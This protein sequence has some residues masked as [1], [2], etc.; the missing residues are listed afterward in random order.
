ANNTAELRLQFTQPLI[1]RQVLGFRLTRNH[2]APPAAWP[3][4]AVRPLQV[5]SVR[6]FIGVSADAGLRLSESQVSGLT[7]IATA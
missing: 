1:G 3:L 4:P 6:G 2:N 5:K 7:E